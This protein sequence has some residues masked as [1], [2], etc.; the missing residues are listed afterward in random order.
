M[1]R[2]KIHQLAVSEEFAPCGA[3]TLRTVRS[4][5]SEQQ[6]SVKKIEI[7]LGTTKM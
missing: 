3:N 6:Q 1:S 7:N 2:A 4:L 5:G